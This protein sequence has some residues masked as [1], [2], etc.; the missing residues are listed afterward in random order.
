VIKSCN[1]VWM[2]LLL[3]LTMEAYADK[4]GWYLGGGASIATYRLGSTEVEDSF[5][6]SRTFGWLFEAGYIWDLGQAGGFHIGISG[7]FNQW[8]EVEK[9]VVRGPSILAT[10]AQVRTAAISLVLEQEIMRWVDFVFKVGPSYGH[11]D[12]EETVRSPNYR[13]QEN[14]N[15]DG[16]GGQYIAGFV[17]FP[18]E[19]FAIEL[20][21]QGNWF[22]FDCGYFCDAAAVGALNLSLQYRF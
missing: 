21:A 7:T 1:L 18:F 2:P 5:E 3:A 17:F 13:R 10:S 6:S 12:A 15:E 14:I 8:A 16:W 19:D 20:A 4:A 9:T 22:F 11:L